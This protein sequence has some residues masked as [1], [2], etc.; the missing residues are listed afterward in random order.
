MKDIPCPYL[1]LLKFQPEIWKSPVTRTCPKFI[2][3]Q[4]TQF[5]P[6]GVKGQNLHVS[7]PCYLKIP[8]AMRFELLT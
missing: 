6:L 1:L 4:K 7:N 2:Y 3:S 5:G 8:L